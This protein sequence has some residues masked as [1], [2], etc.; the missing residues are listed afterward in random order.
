MAAK[1]I[2]WLLTHLDLVLWRLKTALQ[3][4]VGWFCGAVLC[5][6]FAGNCFSVSFHN[7]DLQKRTVE[8]LFRSHAQAGRD[9]PRGVVGSSL[10][11]QFEST[12]DPCREPGM[13]AFIESLRRQIEQA[14]SNVAV[15]LH[16][17]PAQLCA[18]D[19]K[20]WIDDS[21]TS[22][23][24]IPTGLATV[25]Q[26]PATN[27]RLLEIA[28]RS[29]PIETI[30]ASKVPE[31]ITAI[32]FVSPEGIMRY[33][34]SGQLVGLRGD[35]N[36]AAAPHVM[37]A[38]QEHMCSRYIGLDRVG[39]LSAPYLDLTGA[40]VVRTACQPITATAPQNGVLCFDVKPSEQELEERLADLRSTLEIQRAD[41]ML[42]AAQL[43]PTVAFCSRDAKDP[44]SQC[45]ALDP[46]DEPRRD[47]VRKELLDWLQS[48]PH[49]R[50]PPLGKIADL[51]TEG[52]VV[53]LHRKPTQ[54]NP[55]FPERLEVAIIR[56]RDLEVIELPPLLAGLAL[57]VAAAVLVFLAHWRH[58]RRQQMGILR[59]APVGV[60]VTMRRE[61]KD[62]KGTKGKRAV[63]YFGNDRAESILNRELP[64]LQLDTRS[65]T[66]VDVPDEKQQDILK[67]HDKLRQYWI[68]SS[69]DLAVGK[70]KLRVTGS[71]L[72]LANG[73]LA[74]Y[75]VIMLADEPE[76]EEEPK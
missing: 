22:D 27:A 64:R 75:G 28:A 42:P 69:Y 3:D 59:S 44:A 39:A 9:E 1:P 25:A 51:A 66:F 55:S 58:R 57:M 76:E 37:N 47:R 16:E 11:A 21:K 50:R 62:D 4:G 74:T 10:A 61:V 33:W 19:P 56:L 31:K 30:V 73:E 71:P 63:V 36:F 48:G 6:G 40:G 7:R 60:L 20:P 35:V 70:T 18:S 5:L 45:N 41:V 8:Q 72:Q 43:E 12:L 54:D 15:A 53:V 38:G 13:L 68:E 26:T 65:L 14:P 34:P 2:A 17:C 67:K 52:T 49:S 23:L 32:Y 29:L 46:V 24:R